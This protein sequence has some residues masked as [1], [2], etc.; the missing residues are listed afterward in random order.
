MN[1]Q[2]Y[3]DNLSDLVINK[4]LSAKK[5][6]HI[7]LAWFTH[8]DIWKALYL[9]AKQGV[10]VNLLLLDDEINNDIEIDHFVKAFNFFSLVTQKKRMLHHKF[11]VIDYFEVMTG[12][13]N[14]SY[15]GNSNFENILIV[16]GDINLCVKYVSEWEKIAVLVGYKSEYQYETIQLAA[17]DYQISTLEIEKSIIEKQ[18][19]EYLY[20][21]QEIIDPLINKLLEKRLY[22]AK[23]KFNIGIVDETSKDK[24][25][26]EYKKY[27]KFQEAKSTIDEVFTISEE[28]QKTLKKQ[29]KK[30]VLK[31]HPDKIDDKFGKIA[32]KLFKKMRESY[33]KND[34]NGFEKA[35]S[36]IEQADLPLRG[37]PSIDNDIKVRTTTLNFKYTELLDN[38]IELRKSKTYITIKNVPNIEEFIK[39]KKKTLLQEIEL[40]EIEIEELEN[41]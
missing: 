20:F 7:A 10:E 3:F 25:E 16:N 5:S 33:E 11:C 32:D 30:F 8:R 15:K 31:I 9:Q 27:Q 18:I 41:K 17:L 21:N 22:L 14:W 2:V 12:S 23:L 29:F 35:I 37:M 24:I 34:L 4:I 1:T 39:K 40:A 19:N 13:Y 26:E 28:E 6:I 38:L 36:E